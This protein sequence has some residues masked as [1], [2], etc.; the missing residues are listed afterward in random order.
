MEQLST[1]FLIKKAKGK[2]VWLPDWQ[3][4]TKSNQ[5]LSSLQ[6]ME[7]MKPIR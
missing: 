4:L 6:A 5:P 2:V 7:A 1:G 3:R